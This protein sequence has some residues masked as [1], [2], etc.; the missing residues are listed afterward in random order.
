MI[1][2]RNLSINAHT[3]SKAHEGLSLTPLLQ[4]LWVILVYLTPS[5]TNHTV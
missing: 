1:V 4:S 2:V 5:V 3:S